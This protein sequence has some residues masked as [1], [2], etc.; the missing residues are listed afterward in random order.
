[1]NE[2]TTTEEKKMKASRLERTTRELGEA[3]Y[4][5]HGKWL[6]R[7]DIREMVSEIIS[8]DPD[9]NDYFLKIGVT[10]GMFIE[11]KTLTEKEISLL[12]FV[13]YAAK[14]EPSIAREHRSF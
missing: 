13:A 6:E 10:L 1:M 14:A 2:L 7:E 9:L 12:V 8:E 3:I 4:N 11:N 5:E